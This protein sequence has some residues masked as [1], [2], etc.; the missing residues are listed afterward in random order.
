MTS[1]AKIAV[2]CAA[3]DTIIVRDEKGSPQNIYATAN[4]GL[5]TTNGSYVAPEDNVE[6]WVS[7]RPNGYS[8]VTVRGPDGVA[9]LT[10]TM[11]PVLPSDTSENGGGGGGSSEIP[12]H[13]DLERSSADETAAPADPNVRLFMENGVL[14]ARD[15][16]GSLSAVSGLGS[17]GYADLFS[18]VTI[19]AGNKHNYH[20][21]TLVWRDTVT[22]TLAAG[23]GFFKATCEA[24]MSGTAT[25]V[26]GEGTS[27]FDGRDNGDETVDPV[28]RG[29]GQGFEIYTRGDDIFRVTGS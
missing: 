16:D 8:H 29:N 1:F 9:V 4:G 18:S 6:V 10:K 25:V 5:L 14:K 27:G 11:S 3:G 28:V 26:F 13:L 15:S 19:N 7:E 21:K 17:P 23:L 22:V 2:A 24:P 12:T 20:G